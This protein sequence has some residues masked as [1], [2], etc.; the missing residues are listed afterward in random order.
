MR[1]RTTLSLALVA[2][3]LAPGAA[4]QGP[5]QPPPQPPQNLTTP[6]K[7]VLGKILFLSLIHI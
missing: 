6:E 3:A 7:A 5:L 4:A 2:A 1:L